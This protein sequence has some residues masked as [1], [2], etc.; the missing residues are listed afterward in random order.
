MKYLLLILIVFFGTCSVSA[1]SPEEQYIGDDTVRVYPL[2]YRYLYAGAWNR[3]QLISA[4]WKD[5]FRPAV[6]INKGKMRWD[7]KEPTVV[8]ICPDKPKD[9]IRLRISHPEKGVIRQV[10]LRGRE[11]PHPD[12][13]IFIND[14]FDF[15]Q[16]QFYYTVKKGQRAIFLDSTYD[17]WTIKPIPPDLVLKQCPELTEKNPYRIQAVKISRNGMR[18]EYGNYTQPANEPYATFYLSQL[19]PDIWKQ[20]GYPIHVEIKEITFTGVSGK[21][22]DVSN[23]LPASDKYFK[24]EV[25]GK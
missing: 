12:I 11:L 16:K 17:K 23:I 8:W 20:V 9:T 2:T 18:N 21:Q 1:Q 15:R 6:A 14:T 19:Y 13:K 24:F 22:E 3:L 25:K 10:V 5:N 7:Q 4:V